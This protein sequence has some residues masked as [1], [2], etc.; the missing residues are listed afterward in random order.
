M[1][2]RRDIAAVPL[3]VMGACL[4]L[5]GHLCGADQLIWVEGESATTR[6][7]QLNSWYDGAVKKEM[8]SGGAWITNFGTA[9]GTCEYKVTVPQD[10]TYQFWVRCNPIQAA[11]SY[12]IDGGPSTEIDMS[13][14][15]DQVI[16]AND[17]KPDLRF[18][19][20]LKAGSIPLKAGTTTIDFLM[21]SANSHHG[22]IDCFLLTT[23][24]LTPSGKTKPGEKLGSDL[25]GWFAFEPGTDP[26]TAGSGIDLS[27]LN[28]KVAG[29]NGF[30][31][32]KDDQFL[33]GNGTPVRFWSANVA[34]RSIFGKEDSEVDYLAA[35]LAKNGFNMV[36]LHGGLMDRDGTDPG[37]INLG[38][39]RRLQ[40]CIRIF[41]Q[42]GIYCLL[43]SYYPLWMTLKPSDGISG[44]ALGKN[45]FALLF[46]EPT[47]QTMYRSWLK[48]TLTTKDPATGLNLAETPG[49]GIVEINNEDNLFF[50]TFNAKAMGPGPLATLEHQFGTWLT[51]KY[52][53]LTSAAAAW[54]SATHPDDHPADGAM[55]VFDAWNVTSGGMKQGQDKRLR[56]ID[57]IDFMAKTQHDFF[58]ATAQW[59]R[60]TCGVKCPITASNWTTADNQTLGVIERWTYTGAGV[61]DKHGYFGGMHKGPRA[62]YSV[63]A[64]DEYSDRC[65]L[66]EPADV[67]IGY[68][69]IAHHP[70]IHSEIAWNKPNRYIADGDLML[71]T[72]AAVQ[73]INSFFL[74]VTGSGDWNA[75]GNGV[76]TLM[77]P[78]ELGQ[79]PAAALQ[80][81]RGDLGAPVTI[82]RYV[83][84]PKDLLALKGSGFIEGTNADFSANR[85][86]KP[87][88][89]PG[90]LAD[91]DPLSYYVGRVECSFD[92]TDTPI[93]TDLARHIDHDAKVV[94]SENG[95]VTLKYGDGLLTVNTANSQAA[96]GFLSKAGPIT[97]KD[98]TI[99]SDLEY[100]TVHVISFDGKPIA[101]SR[102]V[103]VQSFSEEQFAGFATKGDRI[104]DVGHL[105]IL[106]KELSGTVTFRAGSP[107]SAQ[108]LDGNGY[109]TGSAAIA[110]NVLTLPKDTL[111]VLLT[112]P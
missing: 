92:P 72:Y 58:S 95:A 108:S 68:Y 12:Q 24:P 86:P 40:T 71:S 52:G 67:P 36:R 51:A 45:P 112:R 37:A 74:F 50:W 48:T 43:S 64:G 56:M 93:S 25:P 90:D 42:H 104:V 76:W 77:M 10:G 26:L 59:L 111:Y 46:F 20:W 30:I 62:G 11:L 105:P 109:L 34:S 60:D 41:N 94:T 61:I 18:L 57:Q 38:E 35:R 1:R 65:A 55:G 23:K 9:D 91:F 47:F 79:S 6:H 101:T 106:V 87:A 33:L 83:N 17:D 84:T 32:A 66:L 100:G 99:A 39:L 15:E 88:S 44:S 89:D 22:A 107:W 69:Q 81:R 19:A 63:S 16:I 102:K 98:V 4:G 103:L 31:Q 110:G 53:S 82:R 75:T 70:N 73:G 2:H 5:G 78:G 29:Q 21:H 80:F 13:H 27:F 14:P 28:E 8:I 96:T 7:V 49:V 97:L 3:L 85:G 54:P